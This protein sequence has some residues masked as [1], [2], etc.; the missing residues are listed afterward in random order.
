MRIGIIIGSIRPNRNGLAVAQWVHEHASKRSGVQ[1]ELV[2]IADYNL[3]LLDEP[4]PPSMGPPTKEHTKRWAAKIA[5]F[6]GYV[7]V[8]PEYN[9]GPPASLKNAMDFL[10]KEWC[11][12]S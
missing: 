6:D 3:P 1:Y 4:V 2:D 10:F 12:K 8:T 9:H 11:D 7:F 5:T